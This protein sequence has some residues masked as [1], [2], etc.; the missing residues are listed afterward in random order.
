MFSEEFHNRE[1]QNKTTLLENFNLSDNDFE[2]INN[3]VHVLASFNVA[4]KAFEGE[5]Y[6]NLSLLPMIIHK[7][8]R[9]IHDTLGAIDDDDQPPFYNLFFEMIE[10]F[11]TR[12]GKETIYRVRTQRGV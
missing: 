3:V 2:V 11:E 9:T 10:D 8:R 7:L 1:Q 5:K 6:V 12:W 4:Q